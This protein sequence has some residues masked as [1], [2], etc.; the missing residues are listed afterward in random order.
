[1]KDYIVRAI[2]AEGTVRAFAAV[3]T[4]MVQTAKGIH[5]LSPTATAALGRTLTAAAMMSKTLK[6]IDDTLTIQIRGDGPLGGIVVAT[7][8]YANVRGY[9]YNPD[10][11]I[12]LNT[13]GKLDV[14]Q[15]VGKIGY[16]NII[17]D[18]GLR[19]PYIGYVDLVSGEIGEDIS[20]YLAYSEQVPSVVGLGVLVD[21]DGSVLHSGGFIVQLMPG[22]DENT[23]EYLEKK[24]GEMPQVTQILSEGG[25]PEDILKLILSDMDLKILETT[26][27]HFKCTC[28][29]DRMERNILSLGTEEIADLIE[30]QHGAEL[31]CH[32]CNTR[33][34]FTE[35]DLCKLLQPNAE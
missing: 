4:K 3:T 1:M 35:D 2:A 16:L 22:A 17:K 9:V 10:V 21:R 18:L 6:G 33:Y 14:G 19:E 26:S 8:S 7:D 20:Y 30:T 5:G 28:S 32:F 11:S 13:H 31:E 23:I 25:T 15:A 29:Y 12:P 24:A 34:T 27:C